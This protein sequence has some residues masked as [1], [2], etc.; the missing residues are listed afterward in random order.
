QY[1]IDL[2]GMFTNF[3]LR[4]RGRRWYIYVHCVLGFGLEFAFK[5]AHIEHSASIFQ[6][7]HSWSWG[8]QM[9]WRLPIRLR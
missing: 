3:A 6:N 2:P 8:M 5:L 1:E 7:K 4:E 9:D